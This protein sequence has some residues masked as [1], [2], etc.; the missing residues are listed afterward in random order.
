MAVVRKPTIEELFADKSAIQRLVAEQYAAME[1]PDDPAATPQK[2]Q[3]M[4]LAAG[5]R[6][7][8]NEFSR[9]II[10]AREE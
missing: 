7:E 5:I 10:H 6:P 8:D 2:A 1:I 3:A 9:G 4:T